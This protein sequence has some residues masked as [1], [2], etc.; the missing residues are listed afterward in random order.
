[1]KLML[2]QVNSSS[3]PSD[4]E[5]IQNSTLVNFNVVEK[6]DKDEQGQTIVTYVYWQLVLPLG[7]SQQDIQEELADAQRSIRNEKIEKV[8]WAV[9]RHNQQRELGIDTTL[10]HLEYKE[11]LG[12]IQ[13]L[14]DLPE[15][16]EFPNLNCPELGIEL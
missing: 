3:Y 11:L 2:R 14:R 8:V 4:Q 7:L 9:D 16:S 6:Q 13:T 15:Q 12:Y 5:L 1:M 10:S